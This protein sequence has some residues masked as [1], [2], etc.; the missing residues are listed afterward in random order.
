[1]FFSSRRR[2]TRWP[3]DWS[4]DVCSSD[5]LRAALRS[6]PERVDARA[7]LGLA[8]YNMGDLDGAVEELRAALRQNPDAVAPRL[9]LASTLIARREW[10]AARFELEAVLRAHPDLGQAH[11]SL[12]VVRYA[13][14]DL[15]G[16]ID[17][18]RRASTAD[19]QNLD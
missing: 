5:L 18:Y 1:F 9:T 7:A 16:A 8:L 15:N 11:Y 19:P 3:R 4:S 17:A 14:G 2:H 6:A 13:R 10:E 12:G